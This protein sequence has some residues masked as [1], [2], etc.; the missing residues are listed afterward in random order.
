QGISAGYLEQVFS[1]LRKAGLVKSIKG[2]QGGYTLA[3]KPSEIRVGTVLQALEGSLSVLDEDTGAG[4]AQ[5]PIRRTLKVKV[6][7]AM[8]ERIQDIVDRMRLEELADAYERMK[9][10]QTG[11]YHI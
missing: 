8:D 2:A 6:W 5:D 7:D 9:E 10:N 1:T 4:D 11:M 3:G